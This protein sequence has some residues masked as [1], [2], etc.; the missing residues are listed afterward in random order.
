M[1]AG[2]GTASVSEPDVGN[3]SSANQQQTISKQKIQNCYK[4]I[5]FWVS[6]IGGSSSSLVVSFSIA[7]YSY[8]TLV[9]H[10]DVS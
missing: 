1:P 2:N 10:K 4:K 6:W 5:P 3:C 7:W 9:L 8:S